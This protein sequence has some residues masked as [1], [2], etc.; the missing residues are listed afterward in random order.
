MNHSQNSKTKRQKDREM[1]YQLEGRPGLS[2]A[3]PLG[4][5]HVLA[6]FT[7]NLAPILIIASV[8]GLSG[9]DTVIMVQCAM[10][11]SGLTTFIQ[12]YPIKL[13][14]NRQI[15]ANLPIVMGTSFAFVPTASAIGAASG[16]GAVLGGCLAGSMI[17]VLMGFFYKYIRRFFPPL[18]VGCTLVTIGVNLLDVG[19]DYFAGGS[20][21][22]DY[23]SIQNL[24]VAFFV[25]LIVV[26][27]QRFGKGLLK[28]S[29]ILVGLVAGYVLAYFLGMVDT[30]VIADAAWFGIPLPM[31]FKLEFHLSA[32]LSFAALFVTSGAILAD[33][34]GSTTAAVFN[35]L[36]NTAFGQNAGIVAMT[37]VVNKWCIATGAFILMISGFFPKLGAIFSA[38][39]NAVL[40]GAI[41]TVFGMILI[42]G[43]KMIAKAGFSERNILV[44]GLTFAFGLGMTS[45]PDAVAQLPSALRFIFSD[46]VT[47]TCIVAIVANFLFPM[48]DEED[49]KKAKEA[50]L[51]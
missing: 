14:K 30:S 40:G 8:C 42:N 37:K 19:V 27:L 5:Q 24:S 22:E 38:I 41:I 23:G 26:L 3:V 17:E 47:G 48:K 45:H 6:M 31:Q 51:D 18:V 29:A 32:I 2:T 34:L 44:M 49:I 4:L 1:V 9:A 20:G 50:M 39:P 46:S 16:I 15:G 35:A 43:I 11:V 33:A 21:A 36:P 25:L 7:S 12:L 28:N 10:F 13:G